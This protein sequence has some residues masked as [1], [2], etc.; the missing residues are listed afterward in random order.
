[1]E[2]AFLNRSLTAE[3]LVPAIVEQCRRTPEIRLD[4]QIVSLSEACEVLSGWDG[5]FDLESRGAVLW[6]EF[7]TRFEQGDL[8]DSGVLFADRFDPADPVGTPKG[9]ASGANV[10][11]S[12]GRAVIVLDRAGFPLDVQL[13]ELQHN[14]KNRWPNSYPRWARILG[15]CHKFHELRSQPHNPGTGSGHSASGGGEPLPARR[16]VSRESGNQ[17]HHG[18]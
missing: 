12:L 18:T 9:L 5:R 7:I 16:R 17:L 4:D 6:R 3:L 11:D 14:N 2:A 10:L 15:G 13:G 8:L 1:M